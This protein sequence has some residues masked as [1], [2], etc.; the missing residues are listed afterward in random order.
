MTPLTSLLLPIV[1][2]AAAVFVLTMVIHMTPWHK[3]DYVRLPD[4]D[5]VMKALRAFNLP[6]NDYTAPHPGTGDY[7]KSPEYDAKRA[8]GPVMILTIA[9]SG[10]WNLGKMLGQW[11]VFT[12]VVSASVAFVVGRYVPPSGHAHSVFHHVAAI[13]FVTYAMGG[14]P[15]S[16]WYGRKWSTTARHVVDAM[17][18]ALATA[19]IFSLMWPAA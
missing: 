15:L 2:S 4:E 14:I 19:L 17:L 9:P 16:I 8:A 13:A 11:L 7:M 12:L 6:P 3:G 5:G 10:P 18:N 1:L